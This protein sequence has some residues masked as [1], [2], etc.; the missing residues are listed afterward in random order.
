MSPSLRVSPVPPLSN[1]RVRPPGSKSITNRALLCAAVADGRSDLSGILDCDDTRVMVAALRAL[2][3]AVAVDWERGDATL[4]GCGGPFPSR[5][6]ELSA[7]NSGTTMRFLAAA[8]SAGRGRFRLSGSLR[9]HQRPVG[10]L[11]TAL[12]QLGVSAVAESPNECPPIAIETTGWRTGDVS[13][14]TE[15]S[16][17]FASGLIMAAP[18]A[19]QPTRIQLLGE[20]VSMPYI[21]LTT[22]VMSEFGARVERSGRTVTIWNQPYQGRAYSIEPDASAAS[23]FLAAAA[24]AGGTVT[25]EGL[26]TRSP[27]GDIR[28]AECLER[29]GCRVEMKEK[30]ITLTGPAVGGAE[31]SMRDISDT[32]PTLAVVALFVKGP[33]RISGVSH[34]RGKESNRIGDMVRELRKLGAHVEELVD[35]M[36]ITPC[37]L[38]G[39]DMETHDDHRL[40]MSFSLVGLKIPGVVIRNPQCVAKTYPGYFKDLERVVS[41]SISEIR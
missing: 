2:G 14:G 17:Q 6:A 19:N 13:V 40:A 29:M 24:I 3:V 1:A 15:T 37:P 35:G 39:A 18:L 16:S 27:Q 26:G 8:V 41:S 25:V 5:G 20:T 4:E 31:I 9:M 23:Y 7:G 36:R 28:F 12:R 38:H 22:D 10:D 30:E 34:I 21:D 33:T 11:I 32:V